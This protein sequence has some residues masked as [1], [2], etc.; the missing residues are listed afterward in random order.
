MTRPNVRSLLVLAACLAA[1]ATAQEVAPTGP[2]LTAPMPRPHDP[3]DV[4]IVPVAGTVV[5]GKAAIIDVSVPDAWPRI[6]GVAGTLGERAVLGFAYGKS[7]HRWRLLS[8][9]E[10]D[11]Q[12][13]DTEL[14]V[15]L[16]L[17]DGTALALTKNLVVVEGVYPTSELSVAG[18]FTSPSRALRK[19]ARDEAREM[20]RAL[21]VRSVHRMWR[22]GFVKPVPGIETSPFGTARTYNG[23]KKS[24]HLGL[25]LDGKIGDPIVAAQRGRIVLAKDRFY[26]GGTVVV[27][28][29]QGLFTMYF[30]MSRIDVKKGQ[31]VARSAPLG[32]VG[33]TGQVT[34]PHLHFSVKVGG[35]YVDPHDVLAWDM[36]DDAAPAAEAAR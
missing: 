10:V 11:G 2:A 21:K 22:G 34:G 3:F 31:L 7:D 29:G 25:D 13:G 17:A 28:H 6:T 30:H 8:P 26:S 16:R 23:V 32:L 4:E 1:P 19:R 5:T 15:E 18:K 36:S 14:A 24:R 20:D 33:K 35:V 12:P 9:V 27:D